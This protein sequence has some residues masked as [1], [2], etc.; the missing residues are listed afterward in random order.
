[1]DSKEAAD[2]H[3]ERTETDTSLREERDR[4][5]QELAMQ[6]SVTERDADQVVELARERADALLEDSRQKRGREYTPRRQVEYSLR[7]RQRRQGLP[8]RGAD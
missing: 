6:S 2:A 8:G 1:V 3:P 4:T 5:D 7:R